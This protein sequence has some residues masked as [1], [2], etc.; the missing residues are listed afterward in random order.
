MGRITLTLALGLTLAVSSRTLAQE[1]TPSSRPNLAEIR[2]SDGSIVRMTL[3]QETVEVLTKYGKL[4]I[5]LSDVRRVEFGLHVPSDVNQQINQSIKRLASDVYK[6]R[7][8][9]SK[10]LVQVGHFAY[11]S[12]QKATRSGDQE[13]AYRA[14]SV[15][16]QIS[17]RVSPE[18]LKLREEDVIHTSEFTVIGRI[19][20][21][22]LKAHSPH[23]GEVALKLSELRSM[24]IRQQGGKSELIVDATKHGSSLDQWCDSGITVDASQ[25]IV[26]TA[27]GQVD[28]WPQG[29]GQYMAAPKGYNTAGKGGQ[30]MAGALVGK[31]G[32]TGKAFY[33]G[34]RF[35]G[36]MSEEGRLYL[37]IVPSPWNNAS[38]GQY[39]VNIQT[40]H[41]T[42][43]S[44]RIP[45]NGDGTPKVAAAPVGVGALLPR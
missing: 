45:S 40:D 4:S 3:Q 5:P 18:L 14:V 20:S 23:F 29:P 39:R 13:V 27:E 6:E 11:P 28:L 30:F 19:T 12:L 26:V 36:T 2:F 38:S 22:T 33:I 21:S 17:E 35:D 42:V 37:L 10:D 8:V 34:E 31:I 24:Q 44:S 1:S 32:E 16:K 43:G 15:I 7:D 25:R 41:T 9:A